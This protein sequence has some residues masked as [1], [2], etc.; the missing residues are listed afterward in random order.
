MFGF[1][2]LPW[3][4]TSGAA[5]QVTTSPCKGGNEVEDRIDLTRFRIPR[6]RTSV[7]SNGA[8]DTWKHAGT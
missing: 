7:L 6:N 1:F 2:V 8:D 3:R 4:H 5:L